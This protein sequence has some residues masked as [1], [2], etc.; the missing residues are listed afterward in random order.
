MAKKSGSMEVAV[1]IDKGIGIPARTK[2]SK[3]NEVVEK[4]SFGDSV[5][6]GDH[7][8]ATTLVAAL[9]RKGFKPVSRTV[10]GSV[11]VWKTLPETNGA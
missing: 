6:F 9:K 7:K 10:D 3:W 8:A 4:M 1:K 5:A 2:S 11:R